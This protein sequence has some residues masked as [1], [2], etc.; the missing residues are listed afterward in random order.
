MTKPDLAIHFPEQLDRG[1]AYGEAC[2]ETFRVINGEVLLLDRHLMRL[3]AG[4]ASFGIHLQ[5]NELHEIAEAALAA[6]NRCGEDV[7]V[8]ITVTGGSAGWGLMRVAEPEVYIQSTP[9]KQGADAIN[10]VSVDWPFALQP[11]QAK[12]TADYAL[13]LRALRHWQIEQGSMPLICSGDGAVLS[14][15][16]A[17][18]LI[19]RDG[20]WYTP[21]D[22]AGGVLPG[23]VRALLI[24]A[25]G[26]EAVRCPV[27]WLAE[28]EAIVLTNSSR[29]AT[30]AATVDGRR[31]DPMHSSILTIQECIRMY[32]GVVL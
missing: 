5:E 9:Y 28:S 32:P 12:F 17:N 23:V 26:V 31:L 18:V 19:S 14:S 16:T 27:E 10:L 1:L 30:A 24:E 3:A 4:L 20:Q 6:A 29:F 13:A 21:E 11:K 25:G 15:L 7:Q 22:S 2:F 8:R